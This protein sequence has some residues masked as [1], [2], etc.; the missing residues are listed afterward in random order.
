MKPIGIIVLLLSFV[1]AGCTSVSSGQK[2]KRTKKGLKT[3]TYELDAETGRTNRI[4]VQ[5]TYDEGT[6]IRTR[7]H[8]YAAG[9]SGQNIQGF[10]VRQ[11]PEAQ[12]FGLMATQKSDLDKTIESVGKLNTLLDSFKG[13]STTRREVIPPGMKLVPADDPSQ[14]QPEIP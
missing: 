1:L 11:D 9:S 12:G 3:T 2:D 7:G 4:I 13:T 5:D 14:P 10:Q 6:E 8:A